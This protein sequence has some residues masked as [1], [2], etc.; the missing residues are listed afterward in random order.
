MKFEYVVQIKESH[1]DTFGHMNNA[2]YLQLYE[3]ARWEF[4][5]A[6]GYGLERIQQEQKGPV[7]LEAHIKF[8]KEVKLREK[9]RITFEVQESRGKLMV[10][11]QAMI[12][13][14]EDL[15]SELVITIGFF[16]LKER[17]LIP[18]TEDWITA[19][20]IA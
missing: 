13:E 6:R 15:A 10:I 19:T 14:N 9:I 18:M 16:D 17:K 3:E 2:V 7:I 12:K 5:T 4:I 11:K 8:M 20:K 1:L